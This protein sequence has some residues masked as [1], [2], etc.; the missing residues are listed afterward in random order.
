MALKWYSEGD[1]VYT[2]KFTLKDICEELEV[3]Y[4]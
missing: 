1:G 2:I 3:D 4:V